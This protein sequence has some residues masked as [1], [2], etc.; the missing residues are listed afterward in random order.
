[1]LACAVPFFNACGSDACEGVNCLNGECKDGTCDCDKGWTGVLCDEEREPFEIKVSKIVINKF[2]DTDNGKPWDDEDDG[3]GA[4]LTIRVSDLQNK[5]FEPT[6]LNT[7]LHEN[8]V[9]GKSYEIPCT[10]KLRD[11]KSEVTFE[12]VDYDYDK[13]F[14][15]IFEFIGSLKTKFKDQ[16]SGFPEVIK[17][18]SSTGKTQIDLYCEYS[19]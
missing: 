4:D 13:N 18:T 19:F 17:L 9:G 6:D 2:A 3:S 8:A 14:N 11:M 10:I 15:V 5:Y 7:Q 1:M 12:L 16:Y